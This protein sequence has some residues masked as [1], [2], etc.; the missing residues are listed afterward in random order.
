M[1]SG[2][3]RQRSAN[4]RH[5]SRILS[6]ARRAFRVGYLEPLGITSMMDA[7]VWRDG[8]VIGVVCCECGSRP[9]A[10]TQIAGTRTRKSPA[11]GQCETVTVATVTRGVAQISSQGWSGYR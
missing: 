11:C 2:G 7:A 5:F 1:S 10:D 3:G 6:A 9:H 8:W 4:G